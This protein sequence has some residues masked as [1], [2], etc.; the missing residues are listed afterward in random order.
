MLL[1]ELGFTQR[2]PTILHMDNQSAIALAKNTGSQGRAKHIDIRYHFLRNKIEEGVIPIV[3]FPG[4]VNPA[5]IF[6]KALPRF[7]FELL[8]NLLR[9][10]SSRGSVSE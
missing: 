1:N 10:S 2:A 4:D 9:M 7:R 3:H 8:R 5:D 6:T